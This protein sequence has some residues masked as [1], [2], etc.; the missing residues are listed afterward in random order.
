MKRERSALRVRIWHVPLAAVA[1]ALATGGLG[2]AA[3]GAPPVSHPAPKPKGVPAVAGVYAVPAHFGK[4]PSGHASFHATRTSWPAATT[5]TVHLAAIGKRVRATAAPVWAERVAPVAGRSTGPSSLRVEVLGRTATAAAGVSGLLLSATADHAGPVRL[6]L[7]YSGFAQVYGG[8]YGSR[9]RLVSYPSCLRTTPKVT[10]CRVATPLGSTNDAT[11]ST[12]SAKVAVAQGTLIVATAAASGGEEGS[13][14]GTYAA[15]SLKPSGSWTGGGSSGDFTYS[16]DVTVPQAPSELVPSV[17]LSYDSATTD[18]Q[19]SATQAQASWAGEGWNTPDAYIEQEFQ[20]CSE[21]PEGSA[22]PTKTSDQCYDGPVYTLSLNGSTES[23]VWDT[24]QNLF[25]T[26]DADGTVVKHYCTKTDDPTCTNGTGNGSTAYDQDW[27]QVSEDNGT[28]YSFGRNHLP[29]WT[30]GGTATNSVATEPVYSAHSGDPCYNSAGMSS[31]VC[32]M[33]WRWGL[34][35]TVDAHGSAMAY[36]YNTDTNNYGGYNGATDVSYVRDMYLD[37]IDYGFTDGNAYGTVPDKVLFKTTDRCVSASCGPLTKE[38]ASKWPDVPFDL[39]CAAGAD[40]DSYAPSYYSTVRLT[41]IVTQQYSVSAKI[42]NTVDTYAL[43][44]SEPETGDGTAATLWLT[45]IVHTGSG[46]PGDTSPDAQALPAVTFTPVQLENRVDTLTDGL[47]AFDKFRIG[48]ITTETGSMINVTYDLPD[49]CTAP[50]T[51][52]AATNTSSCYP[53]SWTPDGYTKPITDWFNKWVVSKVVQTDPTGGA[54]AVSTSYEY[55]G[56]AGW[57]YDDNELV[58][59]KYRTYGQFRGWGDVITHLGDGVNDP[60]TT[61]EDTYYRGMS[62]DNDSTVVNVTDSLGGTHEDVDELAGQSLESTAFLGSTVDHSTITSYWVSGA[63]ASRSRTGL[64]ALTANFSAPVEELTRQAVTSSGSTTWRDTSTEHTYNTDP[65]SA[66]FGQETVSY[67]HTVPVNAAYDTCT[68]TAYAAANTA[69]SLAGLVSATETDSVACGGYTAGAK[70]SVPGSVNTLTAPS[71][72]ARPAQVVSATR[73]YYDDPTFAT[74]FP[75]VSAPT[76]GD[77]TMVRL[78]ADYTGGAFTW[79]TKS[80]A[81]FDAAGRKT[82]DYDG[83]GNDTHVDYTVDSVGLLTGTTQKNALGQTS[84]ATIDAQRGRTLT[85][86]DANGVVTTD[87]YDALGRVTSLWLDSR[88][89]SDPANETY[90]YQVSNTGPT[91][92]TTNKMSEGGAYQTSTLIYDGLLRQRQTQTITPMGGRLVTDTFYDTRGWTKATYDGWWDSAT[93]PNITLVS[94]AN[95]HDQVPEQHFL[96]YDSLGDVVIDQNEK[97]GVEVSRTTTID[98][99]D[100]TTTVPPSGGTVTTTVTDPL[101]RTLEI[102]NY[103]TLPSITSPGDP[104]SGRYRVTGGTTRVLSYGYDGHGNQSSTT[105]GSGGPAWSQTYNLLGQVTAQ[106]DPDAGNTTGMLYDGAGNLT[107]ETDARTKITSYSYDL[108]NRKTGEFAAT[109]ANQKTGAAG[110]QAAAWV[111]DNSTGVTG[112]TNAVGQLTATMS[113]SGGQEYKTQQTNFNV[114]GESLGTT[115]TIPSTEGTLAGSYTVK[116]TYTDNTGLPLK[117][118]YTTALDGLPAESVLHTYQPITDLPQGLGGANGI[119]QSTTYDA[120]GRVEDVDLGA[121]PNLSHVVNTY[122]DNN[123]RLTDQLVTRQT[124]TTKNVDEQAYTYDPDGN[125]TTQTGTR[126]GAATPAETQCFQYDGL[127]QLTAG[128]TATDKCAATPSATDTST[129]GDSLGANSAY[130]TTWSI[131]ALGNRSGQV[132][133]AFASGPATDRSTAYGYGNA[134]AQ[135]HTLTSTSTTD[136]TTTTPTSYGYDVA[137][138]MT[139]R[140]AGQGNQTL[141]YDDTGQLTGISGSTAGAASFVYDA[142]GSVLIEKDP[143]TTT[144]YLGDQQL[145]L[146]TATGVVAGTRYYAIPGGGEAIRTGS[147][148]STVT[149]ALSDQHGSPTL[150]LDYTAQNPV[151]R[152]YT[153][154]GDTRGAAAVAPDNRGFL[155]KPADQATGLDLVGA[156]EYDPVVGRFITVDPVLETTDPTQLNGYSYAGNNP[157][158]NADPTGLM[159]MHESTSSSCEDAC[160]AAVDKQIADSKRSSG[161]GSQS[162]GGSSQSKPKKHHHFWGSLGHDVHNIVNV[163]SA[164]APGLTLLFLATA[165]IPGLDVV[166][167]GLALAADGCSLISSGWNTWHDVDEHGWGALKTADF[168]FDAAGV[169]LSLIGAGGLGRVAKGAAKEAK[170]AREEA[171]NI[172]AASRRKSGNNLKVR[173][174]YMKRIKPARQRASAAEHWAEVAKQDAAVAGSFFSNISEGHT[175]MTNEIED[176]DNP[177]A[178]AKASSWEPLW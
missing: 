152:Q 47:P 76:A 32:T 14:G 2:A 116:H 50:V 82:D 124:G 155:D 11:T 33:A 67:T 169:G 45:Q 68:T 3:F 80:R 39:V 164:A 109:V 121:A 6:G 37:H 101:G 160:Q 38:T 18:G 149:F 63:A 91:A 103:L 27:W 170:A 30:S 94:A 172:A 100:R 7:D 16:Y 119:V 158:V 66:N 17:N 126:L 110:N 108:L 159:F 44:Q 51:L 163:G 88:P 56:G 97:D 64:P 156:R 111:Y 73:N 24:T 166:T 118:N 106:T 162:S 75:Q 117:D 177:V 20:G 34:D 130:W 74:T 123:D 21:S 59:A 10:A 144:L 143:G 23:L 133:H 12:L 128:W 132:Q 92:T 1:I 31:S 146:K 26:E 46:K 151:W 145:T 84:S 112:L 43:S 28:I 167:G 138:N 134:G 25:K 19:S 171:D 174:K 136:G 62:K 107:Q 60:Q 69:K 49:P 129:V 102:D 127:D 52:T 139:S 61:S 4:A 48:T 140:N 53:V 85:A 120:Y 71:T 55:K 81:K 40:C 135:P 29:G 93:T 86:T 22:A 54:A 165:E 114:F 78:S 57:H 142:D 148:S 178:V 58:K 113:Y 176:S 122:D 96:T 42:Y 150:Y 98:N 95:L 90:S 137:G 89:V 173:N 65:A 36:Y 153:P 9:L 15:T 105:Q 77:V 141:S 13:Q 154:Y 147:T 168:Y 79:Q 125:L 157:V 5:V 161:G 99:G 70:A 87:R 131:D 72:I 35:Y 104:F 41:S 115:V 83:N 8:D 175:Q